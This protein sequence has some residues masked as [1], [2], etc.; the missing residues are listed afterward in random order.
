MAEVLFLVSQWIITVLFT[1]LILLEVH[2]LIKLGFKGFDR[3]S[4][5]IMACFSLC[6]AFKMVSVTIYNAGNT[7]PA[8]VYMDCL[9][10]MTD[11]AV[12][13]MLYFFIFQM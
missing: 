12:W 3:A 9:N 8:R 13:A 11:N 5:V 4:I 1:A 6:F 2:A 10:M 7:S